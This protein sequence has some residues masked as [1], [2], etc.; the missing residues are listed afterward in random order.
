MTAEVVPLKPRLI[1][2]CSQCYAQSWYCYNDGS[3]ECT[4]CASMSDG[5]WRTNLADEPEETPDHNGGTFVRHIYGPGNAA[6]LSQ[7]RVLKNVEDWAKKGILVHLA[8]WT[9]DQGATSWTNIDTPEQREWF[10]RQLNEL[11][12]SFSETKV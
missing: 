6:D 11:A 8:A 3:I 7:K 5:E 1:W 10:V 12:T 9:S 2:I 4:V